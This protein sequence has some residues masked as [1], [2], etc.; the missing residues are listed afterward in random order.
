MQ[1]LRILLNFSTEE[2]ISFAQVHDVHCMV[3]KF[4]L[5]DANKA[6]DI[7]MGG[8]VRFRAVLVMD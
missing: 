5:K 8:K 6:F 1:R 4:A 3:E 2:A 7:M